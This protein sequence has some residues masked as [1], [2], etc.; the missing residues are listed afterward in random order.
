[1][2]LAELWSGDVPPALEAWWRWIVPLS[3]Q[4][5]ALVLVALGLERLFGT[6]ARP[7]VLAA[8]WGLLVL[9]F[10]L[11][12]GLEGPIQS[13]EVLPAPLAEPP[14]T[15]W[16]WV[17]LAAFAL[18][19]A[20]GLFA[21]LR[22]ARQL[23]RLD[24]RLAGPR[25]PDLEARLAPLAA[26]AAAALGLRATPRLQV[27]G[28][29]ADDAPTGPLVCGPLRPRV[30]VPAAFVEDEADAALETALLHEFA[31]VARRDPLRARAL[32]WLQTAFWFHPAPR[33][34]ARRLATLA[35]AGADA[36]AARAHTDGREVYRRRLAGLARRMLER[37]APATGVSHALGLAGHGRELLARLAWLSPEP[38]TPRT[39]RVRRALQGLALATF[40]L[41]CLPL[42]LADSDWGLPVQRELAQRLGALPPEPGDLE[43]CLQRRYLLFGLAA[44]AAAPAA[45]DSTPR[46]P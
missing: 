44:P 34:A 6:R 20:G 17:P 18:W 21:A 40:G 42:A 24:R 2:T 10:L 30:L 32:A 16:S 4:A 19:I 43:G 31:H 13:A 29:T 14:T 12:P 28:W 27:R 26:R 15:A 36:R 7:R 1:M 23:Q 37:G 38:S 41:A 39:R 33:C 22:L 8:I 35:E 46:T 45:S 11:P 5:G 3:L 9:R 25:H